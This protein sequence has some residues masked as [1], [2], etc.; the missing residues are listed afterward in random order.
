MSEKDK[1]DILLYNLYSNVKND[2]NFRSQL[3]L[4][5]NCYKVSIDYLHTRYLWLVE[6][7]IN[8][9]FCHL[10]ENHTLIYKIFD[11]Y[12]KMLNENNI[13]Y[14]YTSGI[15]AYLLAEKEL[16]RYHHDLDVFINMENLR[17]LEQICNSY[18]FSFERKISDRGDGT[19]RVMLKMYY[20]DIIDIPITVFMYVREKDG[21]ILQKDYFFNECQEELV[22]YIHNSPVISK[23][24]FSE[25]PKIHN[26]IR[27]YSITPEALFLCKTGNRPKDIYDCTVFKD[28]VDMEKLKKLT[29]AFKNN[30]PNN[31]VDAKVDE[32]SKFIFN[33]RGIKKELIKL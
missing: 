2:S 3:E 27:Y 4:I 1:L 23:L 33:D 28:I 26:N 10:D 20:Q 15:L 7:N 14:Y 24:S 11:A 18:G 25:T 29:A 13:E 19:K 12:N 32:F 9:N 21:S 17:K 5:A 8:P 30:L 22:E 16:E 6:M 31:V